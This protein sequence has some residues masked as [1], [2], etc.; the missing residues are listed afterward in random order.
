VEGLGRIGAIGFVM[1]S[2]GNERLYQLD[3]MY[4]ETNRVF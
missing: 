3:A 2:L 4:E 1:S